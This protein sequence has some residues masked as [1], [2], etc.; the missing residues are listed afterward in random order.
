MANEIFEKRSQEHESNKV[1]VLNV[2]KEHFKIYRPLY[3]DLRRKTYLQLMDNFILLVRR[4][5]LL[6]TAFFLSRSTWL[7]LILFMSMSLLDLVNQVHSKPMKSV[8]ANRMNIFN[9]CITLVVSYFVMVIN[10]VTTNDEQFEY[11][12]T[13]ITYILYG[14]ASINFLIILIIA[15]NEIKAVCLRQRVK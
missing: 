7:Q 15:I 4:L 1:K 2:K 10:G 13:M 14:D 6:Y 11:G 8:L 9:E 5:I 12:G 3:S